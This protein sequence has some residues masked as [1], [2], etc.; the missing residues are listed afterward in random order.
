MQAAKPKRTAVN[1]TGEIS[2]AI[3][4]PKEKDPPMSMEKPSIAA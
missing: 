3:I 4:D 1:A 2:F